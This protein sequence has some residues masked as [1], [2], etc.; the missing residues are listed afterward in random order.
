MAEDKLS[1]LYELYMRIYGSRNLVNEEINRLEKEGLSREEAINRLY[2]RDIG[3]RILKPYKQAPRPRWQIKYDGETWGILYLPIDNF[4]NELSN[5]GELLD[6]VERNCGEV[7]AIVPNIGITST[8]LILG[9][10]FQGVKGFGII[11]RK[12]RKS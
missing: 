6:Y 1:E 4:E 10:S 12:R 3:E 9:T 5:L 11:Y 7:V 8:S 2:Q